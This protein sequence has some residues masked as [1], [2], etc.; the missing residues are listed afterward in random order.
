MNK[1]LTLLVACMACTGC[2]PTPVPV[3]PPGP[4]PPVVSD[5]SRPV[6][7]A[8]PTNSVFTSKLFDCT[9]AVVVSERSDAAGPVGR[10]LESG[11]P[12]DCLAKL[13]GQYRADTVACTARDLG[14][15]ARIAVRSGTASSGDLARSNNSRDWISAESLGYR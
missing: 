7:D 11:P 8:Y 9:L 5:A 4:T 14:V 6:V 2:P 3:P 1:L 12:A 13:V 15:S 10:C